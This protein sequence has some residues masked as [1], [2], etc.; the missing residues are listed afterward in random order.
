MP[1]PSITLT[2]FGQQY[3]SRGYPNSLHCPVSSSLS[4]PNILQQL[5][6]YATLN[7]TGAMSIVKMED[8]SKELCRLL[9]SRCNE[10][11]DTDRSHRPS[12]GLIV[13]VT[14]DDLESSC[15]PFVSQV[16]PPPGPCGDLTSGSVAATQPTNYFLFPSL[17][18]QLPQ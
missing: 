4:E 13:S 5:L 3:P 7:L 15:T 9:H 2:T 8:V 18:H 1:N 12:V 6:G 17:V 10:H 14:C 16:T 11:Y